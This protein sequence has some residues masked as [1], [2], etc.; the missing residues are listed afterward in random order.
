MSVVDASKAKLHDFSYY[1]QHLKI[2]DR[3]SHKMIPL[4]PT[5]IQQ[6]VR[7][8]I[9]KAE[10]ERRPGRIIVLKARREGVSTIVQATFAHRAF[11]RNNVKAYTIADEA[12]SAQNLHG[13]TE[14]MYENLPPALQPK[15]A[16]GSGQ[17]RR[18]RLVGG[19]DLRTETAQDKHAGRSGSATLVHASEFSFWPYPAETLTAMLQIVPDEPN[20]LVVIES[21]ANGVGNAFHEEWLRASDGDSAYVPLFFSWLDDPGYHKPCKAEELGELDDEEELLAEIHKATIPQLAWRRHKIRQDLQ[22]RVE[23]FH[24]EYPTTP[25]EAFLASGRQFFGAGAIARMRPAEPLGR[26][27]LSHMLFKRRGDRPK[28]DPQGPLWIYAYPAP[29]RRYVMFVDPAGTVSDMEAKHFM[30]QD[31]VEDFTCMWVVDCTNMETVAVWHARIDIGLAGEEAARLGAVYNRA[32]ACAEISGGYGFVLTN[33]WRE[34]GYNP[35]HRDR[36]R[37]QYDRT[38]VPVYGFNTNVATRPLMLETLRDILR[39]S[40]ELLKHEGLKREMSTFVTSKGAPAAAG[41]SHD[42]QV[43]AAAGCYMIATD[44]AQRKP[45]SSAQASKKPKPYTD[46]LTRATRRRRV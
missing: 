17:G 44:Y 6:K 28:R 24:Q 8:E 36:R 32:V 18:L 40:P 27:S 39:E 3:A 45:I 35:I 1:R 33:K 16:S 25:E 4:R 31:E 5:L 34:L 20:T 19:S 42:D 22:G 26:F 23:R 29:G 12:D 38:A 30:N 37:N 41:G 2:Q 15:K 11:T 10:R 46:V 9:L 43:M 7:D 14:Q 21:T 13:M